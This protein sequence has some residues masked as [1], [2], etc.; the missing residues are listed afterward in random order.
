MNSP[1]EYNSLL[2]LLCSLLFYTLL[3]E[4][5]IEILKAVYNYLDVVCGW[6]DYWNRSAVRLA[7]ELEK[8]RS[9]HWQE[10]LGGALEDYLSDAVPGYEGVNAVAAEKVRTLTL[11]IV[12]RSLAM[13]LGIALAFTLNINL[14]DVLQS[15]NEMTAALDGVVN[16]SNVYFNSERVPGWLGTLLT[17]LI[18]GLG[19]DPLH[20]VI[21]RLERARKTSTDNPTGAG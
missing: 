19:S 20:Q 12:I 15:M 17:G 10:K 4:R 13:L 21:G 18:M 3:L 16:R 11:Q 5:L 9:Q 8:S 14:F 1:Q 6:Q 7:R 2:V